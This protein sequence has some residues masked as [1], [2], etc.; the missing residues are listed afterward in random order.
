M[1]KRKKFSK[2]ERLFIANRANHCCEYCLTPADFT[3]D[4]FELEHII[5][6]FEGGTNDLSNIAYSC[7]GC[8]GHKR[9]KT[10]AVDPLS[11]EIISLFNP[12]IHFWKYHF[13]WNDD[14][15]LVLALTAEGRATLE[16]LQLNR[17]GL[18]N[19]RNALFKY[20]VHP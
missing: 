15:S 16:L 14:F 20:G 19:L 1:N 6:L 12:R 3:P 18:I 4:P 11:K 10:F 13:R 8:N 17:I 9:A 5:P 2:S 7:S